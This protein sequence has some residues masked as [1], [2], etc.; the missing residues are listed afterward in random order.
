MTIAQERNNNYAGSYVA[1][2]QFH[3][4]CSINIIG[5][6]NRIKTPVRKSDYVMLV[7]I[8]SEYNS[9]VIILV[10]THNL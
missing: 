4:I 6:K 10:H 3:D 1:E 8:S 9:Y 2:K 7:I 5:G